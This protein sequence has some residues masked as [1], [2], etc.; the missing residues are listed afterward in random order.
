MFMVVCSRR[1]K[2]VGEQ[3]LPQLSSPPLSYEREQVTGT[4]KAAL[5]QGRLTEDE[6]DAR[7]A[8]AS[9]AQSRAE[10]APLTADLPAGL[11]ARLPKARDAW[12]GVCVSIAAA[13][14]LA[15]LVLWAPDNFLA[16]VTALAAAATVLLAPPV[17]VGLIADARHQKRSGRSLAS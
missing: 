11:S 17:T 8:Q 16:F 13:G 10:L 9:A 6:Y 3:P 2:P 7:A 12:A 5:A 14:V 15:V 4:L 1:A